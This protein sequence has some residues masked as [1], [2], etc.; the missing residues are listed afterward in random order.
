MFTT[1]IRRA[2]RGAALLAALPAMAF[3]QPA[4]P[5]ANG[6]LPPATLRA[7]ADTV[8]L[9]H[10]SYVK[11]V[12]NEELLWAAIRGMVREIDPE[13]GEVFLP[14]EMGA[15]PSS[16]N[17]LGGVGLEMMARD[18][19]VIVVAPL[20]GSPAR[21][22]GIRPKDVLVSIDGVPVGARTA[23]AVKAL[24]GPLG[25]VV[26]VG[27][28][29]PS[30]EGLRTLRLERRR[31]EPRMVELSMWDDKIAVLRV[32][33][34]MATT[35][36]MV[37]KELATQWQRRPF[38]TLVIDLRHNGG[39]LLEASV[40]VAS[41]FLPA[42]AM[43]AE[44]EGRIAS[45]NAVYLADLKRYGGSAPVPEL[46][47]AF[48]EMPIVVLV[49]EGTAS[50]AEI[51][52]SALRDNGRARIVGRTTFGRASIQTVQAVGQDLAIKFTAAQW[53]P[54]SHRNLDKVGIVPDLT[55]DNGNEKSELEAA[56]L[57]ARRLMGTKKVDRGL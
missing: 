18:G 12:S 27:V 13:G 4:T 48:R 34:F 30:A 3:A 38:G 14:S 55:T 29:S 44:T 40:G 52:A 36:A 33:G 31:I 26:E 10:S 45:V 7:F 54:P 46:P 50:G 32:P 47:S 39:G 8:G 53:Y 28:R 15:A 56:V 23:W 2:M 1:M 17:G 11:P 21:A 42:N 37:A 25:S 22:A 35:V 20:L 57:E 51:L 9:L 19:V 24:R 43:V 41:L 5:P 49:D 16:T 6:P